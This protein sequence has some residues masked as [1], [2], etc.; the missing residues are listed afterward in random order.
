[1]WND[2]KLMIK[3]Y[4]G[5]KCLWHILLGIGNLDCGG[6]ET[7]SVIVYAIAIIYDNVI[8]LHETDIWFFK[9]GKVDK[10]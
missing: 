6:K 3:R 4:W 5:E 9:V 7:V 1:M 8:D 2:L 10:N